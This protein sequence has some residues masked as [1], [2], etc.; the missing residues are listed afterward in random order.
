M[1]S[2]ERAQARYARLAEE[3][4]VSYRRRGSSDA[5]FIGAVR[6]VSSKGQLLR[7]L[8]RRELV[9]KYK[10]SALGLVWSLVRPL[11]QL[12]VYYW[13][14]GEFIGAARGLNN[15]A[16]FVFSGLTLYGLFS[17]MV[18]SMTTSIVGNAGLVKK[19]YL[20]REVFPLAAAGAAL[21]NFSIQLAIL[22]IAALILGT[23]HFGVNLLLGVGA[24]VVILIWALAIGI[25]LAA[26]NVTSRDIQFM[27]EV[28]LMLLMWFSPIVYSWT[29][30]RDAFGGRGLDWV[31][32]IYLSNPI[33]IGT[34]GF[35]EAF[36]AIPSGGELL[37]DLWL[38]MLVAG[39]V[40]L[41]ALWLC[42]RFFATRQANFAQEL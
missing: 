15:F 35:Q 27:V 17:E 40:G 32:S 10:D 36:W 37:P 25:A 6:E 33:T 34:I 39:G 2:S 24:F 38:R 26:A 13:V 19:V 16:I 23:I 9:G 5:T 1:T 28:V 31:T 7:Q 11:T 14:M 18:S 20:P 30:V 29:M 12:F 4:L 22:T 42:Q 3:S 8:I 21:F 41:I